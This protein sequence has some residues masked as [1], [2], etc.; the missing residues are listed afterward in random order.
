MDLIKELQNYSHWNEQEEAD[1][2]L[3]LKIAQDWQGAE[4]ATAQ[5]GNSVI[6][7]NPFTR[8]NK[9]AHFTASSWIVNASRTKVLMIYH[10]IYHSWSWTGGHAD[11]NKDLLEVA[12]QEA[13]E[14]T[15]ITNIQPITEDIFSLEVLT[16]DGHMKKGEYVSSHLHLNVTFLLEGNEEDSLMHCPEENSAVQWFDLEA[17]VEASTEP[18][19][20]AW[21]YKKLNDKLKGRQ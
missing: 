12:L 14:E 8:D 6:R 18:W 13:K 17:A 20:K 10:N 16:V 11:G 9:I 2:A 1:R 4:G 5:R 3:M 19:F 7:E 21:V 15:G